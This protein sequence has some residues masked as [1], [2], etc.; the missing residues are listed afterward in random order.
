MDK[1]VKEK[2]REKEL[3]TKINGLMGRSGIKLRFRSRTFDTFMVDESNE[4]AYETA[5]AYAENFNRAT[6]DGLFFYGNFGTG[7][8]HLAV[9]IAVHV[10][11]NKC[12]YAV[13]GTL[14]ELL[15]QVKETYDSKGNATEQEV[16][17][18]F[19]NCDLLVID[20]LGKESITDWGLSQ[21][22]DIVNHRYENCK[23]IVITTNYTDDELINR[24]SAKSCDKKTAQAIVSRL[25]EICYPV[26][27]QWGDIRGRI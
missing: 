10:I 24:L 6:E 15:S 8:T 12:I 21:L 1:L 26:E 16:V 11:R 23:P 3:E 19:K 18:K 2:I 17:R 25:H 13:L 9:A 22:Y 7:K 5:K 4:G 27:F 20:D 14:I